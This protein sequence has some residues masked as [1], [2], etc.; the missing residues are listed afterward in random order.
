MN[1]TRNRGRK[2]DG[3]TDAYPQ[4]KALEKDTY[5]A[6]NNIDLLFKFL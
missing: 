2:L 4:L 6:A 3:M 5:R 1:G